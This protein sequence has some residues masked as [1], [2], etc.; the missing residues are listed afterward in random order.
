M[1]EVMYALD[2]Y[3][4]E[5]EKAQLFKEHENYDEARYGLV[6]KAMRGEEVTIS[7]KE[8]DDDKEDSDYEEENESKESSSDEEEEEELTPKEKLEILDNLNCDG[9]DDSD[10]EM[11][12]DASQETFTC[13]K[14]SF[15]K[16]QS[17]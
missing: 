4:Q 6:A 11:D 17:L 9:M 5:Y 16:Q 12:A 8:E 15:L 2:D 7:E 10:T 1:T 14:K 3:K 13:S